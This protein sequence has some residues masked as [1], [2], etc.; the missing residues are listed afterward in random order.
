MCSPSFS[1]TMTSRRTA[2]S[3]LMNRLE[4]VPSGWSRL[5]QWSRP[6]GGAGSASAGQWSP[7]VLESVTKPVSGVRID[8]FQQIDDV[9]TSL[10]LPQ[11]AAEIV[12]F[13]V[14]G[15]SLQSAEV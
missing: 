14:P 4:S 5:G 15:D 3:S 6:P 12:A 9:L 2:T 11:E 10:R 8:F 7:A 1:R 13:E